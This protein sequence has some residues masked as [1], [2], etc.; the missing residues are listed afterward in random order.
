M[1][2]RLTGLIVALTLTLMAAPPALAQ[3]GPPPEVR[4]AVDATLAML[5]SEGD[6]PIATYIRERMA[7]APSET[8]ARTAQLRNVRAGVQGKLGDGVGVEK[9]P[10]GVILEVAGPKGAA[11][12][13]LGLTSSGQVTRVELASGENGG[14]GSDARPRLRA[15]EKLPT[16]SP[17][18]AV[19]TFERDHLS[20]GY[21]ARTS[22]AERRAVIERARTAVAN[23]G[24]VTV[25]REGDRFILNLRGG[26]N[27]DI[28]ITVEPGA[29]NKIETLE[30][31]EVTKSTAPAL[32]EANLVQ[33]FEALALQG[34][35]GT[36][37]VERG[38]RTLLH[39][40]YGVAN[41]EFNTP[42]TVNTVFGIG[43]TPIDFT[44]TSVLLL[45]QRGAL[46]RNDR[47]SRYFPDVPPD[48]RQI[49]IT[50][51]MSGASG[52]PDFVHTDED[53]N[54]DLAWEDRVG[55]ERRIL[56]SRLLFAPGQSRSHSHA[57]FGLLAALV[58][59]LSG[60]T[61]YAFIRQNFLDPAG[62]T[63]TGLYGEARGLNV[64][65][66]AVGPG[67]SIV[68]VPNIPPNWGPTSWLVM[69]SG[70]MYSTLEDMQRFFEYVRSGAVL[71]EKYLERYRRPTIGIGGSDQ[72][73]YLLY[74]TN[75]SD[76]TALMLAA[77]GG[78]SPQIRDLSESLATFVGA[79]A[80]AR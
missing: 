73:F 77:A 80:Q 7:P 67:P 32:T 6:A 23:A 33:T 26:T 4:A 54:P 76:G 38:G 57:A 29:P 42:V 8:T 17:D 19:D 48:K 31:R 16:M 37:H 58:E 50:Q 12:V 27:A 11:R 18:V 30:I 28:A 55:M 1:R 75:G 20:A 53:W 47:I 35:S 65:D 5:K 44:I 21:M 59:R 71:Q 24:A 68:G 45:E 64:R 62:M 34:F 61:Y 9:A 14:G 51:L 52:L 13:H 72:G 46:N 69:G 74:A 36:V 60:Q 49:T 78:R 43:S 10:D 63:R 41:A 56:S 22:A 70:G 15:L 2:T 3:D 66:F 39:R 25:Q 79:R 40:A